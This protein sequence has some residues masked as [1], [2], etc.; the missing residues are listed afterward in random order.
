M[1]LSMKFNSSVILVLILIAMILAGC[2]KERGIAGKWQREDGGETVEY[3]KDGSFIATEK[4]GQVINAQYFIIDENQMRFQMAG[5]GALAGPLILKYHLS[6]DEL[7]INGPD[8]TPAKYHR[9]D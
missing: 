8:G 3:Q 5:L 4:N 9:M 6:G 1:K 2:A 7:S